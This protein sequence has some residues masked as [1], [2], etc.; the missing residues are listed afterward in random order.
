MN[1]LNDL[2][3]SNRNWAEQVEA[4]QPGFFE[5]MAKGQAPEVLWIGC[6]DS[7]VPPT[8]I[9][10]LPPGAMFV[11]RN[12]ANQVVSTDLNCQSVI[13]YAV[14]ALKVK[15]IVVCGHYGCGGV[16]AAMNEPSLGLIEDWLD[17]IRETYKAHAEEINSLEDVAAQQRRLCELNVIAQVGK[18][19]GNEFVKKAWDNNSPI[20]VHGW[21]FDLASGHLKDLDITAN[22]PAE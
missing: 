13:Q 17:H 5:N 22:G 7:R 4:E 20:S 10:E 14:Q 21:I 19:C 9:T 15:H 8:T 6:A 3:E 16:A 1:K 18:V 12:I 2:L 11:H